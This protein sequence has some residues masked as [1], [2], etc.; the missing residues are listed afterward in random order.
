MGADVPQ[1]PSARC[2]EEAL[3]LGVVQ[4]DGVVAFLATPLPVT[5]E[6]AEIAAQG[7]APEKRFRFANTCRESGCRQW[8]G[9]RC[10]VID[11]VITRLCTGTEDAPLPRC[12][13]R[14]RCRW[15]AQTGAP[16]CHVCRGV[17]TDLSKMHASTS[18]E[19]AG[20]SLPPLT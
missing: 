17:V 13:L 10:G 8:D 3:L 12:A 18:T 15:F 1:C 19:A 5:A 9:G 20:E 2:E 16:A 4:A 7:R 14:P 6:F 11:D